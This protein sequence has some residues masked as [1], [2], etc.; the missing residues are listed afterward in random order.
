MVTLLTRMRC[1]GAVVGD[2]VET[3]AALILSDGTVQLPASSVAFGS[4]S[5]LPL[6]VWP[7]SGASTDLKQG[8]QVQWT[9]GPP[10]TC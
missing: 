1:A 7:L 3:E 5:S 9:A 8:G 6:S 10:Q 4:G 2:E